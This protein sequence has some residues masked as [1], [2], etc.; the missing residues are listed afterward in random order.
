MTDDLLDQEKDEAEG[1]LTYVTLLGVAETR[2]RIDA[3]AADIRGIMGVYEGEAAAYL[4]A[5]TD[6]IA[7]RK[8]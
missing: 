1:K 7:T 5:L 6:R 4:L 8:A 2:R 3:L